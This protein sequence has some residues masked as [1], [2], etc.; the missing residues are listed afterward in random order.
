MHYSKTNFGYIYSHLGP[1]QGCSYVQS[2]NCTNAITLWTGQTFCHYIYMKPNENPPIRRFPF[3]EV[4][5][6][7]NHGRGFLLNTGGRW[8]PSTFQFAVKQLAQVQR[9]ARLE[10]NEFVLWTA[11]G[12]LHDHQRVCQEFTS[13]HL[14]KKH[15]TA[16]FTVR[17][18]RYCSKKKKIKKYSCE[19]AQQE[20]DFFFF[21]K[22]GGE[23]D[24]LFHP[25]KKNCKIYFRCESQRLSIKHN[26][27][28]QEN[29]KV[30]I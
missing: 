7:F 15:Y 14:H 21:F 9:T 2:C 11:A 17:G 19:W 8:V 5:E 3:P 29:F 4:N 28:V 27:N 18:H 13:I 12:V 30:Y 24:F 6:N 10:F 16:N 26:C 1:C 22:G 20:N 25:K 23:Y